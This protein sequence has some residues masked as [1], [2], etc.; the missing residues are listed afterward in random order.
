MTAAAKPGPSPTKVDELSREYLELK[1]RHFQTTL[2]ARSLQAE[3]ET[4]GNVLRVL[5]EEHGSVHAEKSKLLHG[6]LYEVMETQ[7]QTVTVDAAAVEKFRLVAAKE[8]KPKKLALIFE[9]DIRY[10]LMA[11]AAEFIRASGELSRKAKALYAA[12][13][14][15]K[16]RTPT[17]TVRLKQAAN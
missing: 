4:L 6:V 8:L 5:A 17:L 14:V 10:R 3:L 1:E 9:T 13:T 15:V 12:C 7:G 16:D 11:T 2:E